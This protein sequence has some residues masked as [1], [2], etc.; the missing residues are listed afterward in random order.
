M[1]TEEAIFVSELR[2]EFQILQKEFQIL[3]KNFNKVEMELEILKSK[4]SIVTTVL[5]LFMVVN[6]IMG[7]ISIYLIVTK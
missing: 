1:A 6:F 7:S 5:I 2:T 3:Q 4:V